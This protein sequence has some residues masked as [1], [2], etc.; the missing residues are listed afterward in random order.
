[1]QVN[2]TRAPNRVDIRDGIARGPLLSATIGG[3]IDYARNEMRISGSLV[4]LYGL[5]NALGNI[6]IVGN[7]LGGKEGLVGVD[8]EAAGPSSTPS[9]RV[10]PLSAV[11]PGTLRKVFEPVAPEP[12][13]VS[14]GSS[15]DRYPT[16]EAADRVNAGAATTVLVSL[17]LD[18]VTP[19]VRVLSAGEGTGTTPQGALSIAVPADKSR[20]PIRVVLHAAGFDLDPS[21]P[22]EATIDLDRT[23][24]ST[25][26][27]FRITARPGEAGPRSLRVTF[28]RDNEFL[29]QVSR[30]IEIVPKPSAAAKSADAPPA[31]IATPVNTVSAMRASADDRLSFPVRPRPIDLK[32][33]I[34]YDDPSNLGHGRVTIAS[35]Y[36]GNMRHGDVN[37]SPE[38]FGWIESFYRDLGIS[39]DPALQVPANA[40]DATPAARLGRLRA[41]GEEL[42]RRAAPPALQAALSELLANPAVQLRTVQIYSNSPRIPWE[43][44]RAPKS[45][46][47]FTDFF[48]IAF[49]LARW[50][51]EDGPRPV[52]RPPQD[53]EIDEV[54]TIA[55]S[56]SGA[57]ALGAQSKEIDAIQQL[58]VTR[59][60]SG[61]R[62]DFLSL[63]RNP[64]IG[65]I[66]FAGHGEVAGRTPVDRRFAIWLEDGPV[67]VMDWRGAGVSRGRPRALFFFNAC[68]I[69]KAESIA[70][71][72]D[73][74]APAVLAHGAAGFIG[75]LWPLNDDPAAQFAIAFYRAIATRLATQGRASV[76]DA[77]ADAR[78]L[79]YKTGDPT[80][81]GYAFY[82]DAQLALVRH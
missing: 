63:A 71:A 47:S 60:L 24:D 78:R 16:I 32:I 21:T 23:G 27:R 43:L 38:L 10:N 13:F 53:Q 2:F 40:V 65:I 31:P 12:T 70:G 20:V 8:F 14:P 29:A 82:G 77:L 3:S 51:E 59:R 41:F 79:V 22:E 69:G 49:A 15:I 35:D 5:N 11:S 61:K 57:Q 73:G 9:L 74:W 44:M 42:Y 66:H 58:L 48:G 56:Y 37:T 55:P 34:V 36:L 39:D 64:P 75:G 81:L 26:A 7:L 45:D 76:A 72:V 54:V 1:M 19:E 30:P 52:L 18:K 68:E 25:S 62:V 17:T 28:W 46:G 4:P 50:H 6:P 80:Y 33:E 67:D